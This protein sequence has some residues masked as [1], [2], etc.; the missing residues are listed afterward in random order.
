MFNPWGPAGVHPLPSP[1]PRSGRSEVLEGKGHRVRVRVGRWRGWRPRGWGQ[2][3]VGLRGLTQSCFGSPAPRSP[4]L[5]ASLGPLALRPC[6]PWAFPRRR[7]GRSNPDPE[8]E[9]GPP[10]PVLL[11]GPLPVGPLP[12]SGSQQAA[13]RSSPS[14][15]PA[16][17]RSACGMARVSPPPPL[18]SPHGLFWAGWGVPR[19]I[20][21]S[22]R[23]AA[24]G[25]RAGPA[26]L[27]QP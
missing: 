11:W 12:H 1:G 13:G 8:S 21:V 25:T 7:P 5:P 19:G 27:A 24:A 6:P 2:A 17:S 16:L 14:C 18:G 4:H 15:L 26:G 10:V 23:T 3:E 9:C 20:L 22:G